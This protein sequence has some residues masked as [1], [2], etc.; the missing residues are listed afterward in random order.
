MKARTLA[1][2]AACGVVALFGGWYFGT[3]TEPADQ[4]AIAGGRLMFPDLAAKLASVAQVEIRHQDTI[5]VIE[6]RP[7]GQWGLVAL[8]GYPVQET[9]LRGLLTGLTEL[10]LMEPRTANPAEFARLGV[11]DPTGKAA[12]SNLLTLVDTAGKPIL[13]VVVG[14][15]RVRSQG[16]GAEEVYVRLP[17]QNQSW[18]A[19]GSVSADADS[20]LWL[21]RNIVNI[22]HDRIASVDVNDHALVFERTD[23]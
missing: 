3:R 15:R 16:S 20:A 7:D 17:D 19:Q 9:K 12:T 11:E 8:R 18:L 6:K 22:G 4:A 5:L 23:G 21:D 14:H 1:I 10:R 13:S 2:L